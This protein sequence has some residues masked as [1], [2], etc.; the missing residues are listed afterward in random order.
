MDI[1]GR[2]VSNDLTQMISDAEQACLRKGRPFQGIVAVS[3]DAFHAAFEPQHFRILLSPNWLE[4][5]VAH[6]LA[7][8]LMVCDGYPVMGSPSNDREASDMSG[9]IDGVANHLEVI[10]RMGSYGFRDDGFARNEENAALLFRERR[11]ANRAFEPARTNFLACAYAEIMHRSSPDKAKHFKNLFR[12]RAMAARE[13]GERL[14]RIVRNRGECATASDSIA[15]MSELIL[16]L[17][18][19]GRIVPVDTFSGQPVTKG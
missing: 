16:V 14:L 11:P 17:G 9:I 5:D 7:H 10:K 19:E 12:T 13:L 6:E 8:V 3:T 1:L 2:T 15:C 4:S 18:Y